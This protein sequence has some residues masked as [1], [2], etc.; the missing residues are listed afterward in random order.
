[1]T[2]KI[3][4]IPLREINKAVILQEIAAKVDLEAVVKV[5]EVNPMEVRHQMKAEAMDKMLVISST[6]SGGI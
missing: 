6:K 5:I 2:G 1:M 4:V 3:R